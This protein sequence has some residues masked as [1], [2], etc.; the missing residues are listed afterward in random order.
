MPGFFQ[1][2]L[3]SKP[4]VPNLPTLDPATEA[5]KAIAGNKQNLPAAEGLVASANRFS[6]DQITS[7]LEGTIPGY[8]SM[9]ASATGNI[10]SELKGE[11]PKDVADQVQN[12]A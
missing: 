9:V 8:K 12:S 11:I 10:A 5:G 3:G 6:Q 7:M 4:V 1:S 2:L